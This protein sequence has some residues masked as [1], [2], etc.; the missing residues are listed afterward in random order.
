MRLLTSPQVARR[1]GLSVERVRQLARSGELPPDQETELGR[2]WSPEVVDLYLNSRRRVVHK[3]PT[4]N[5]NS[6]ERL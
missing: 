4:S 2:L 3:S 1:L 6:E 5:S